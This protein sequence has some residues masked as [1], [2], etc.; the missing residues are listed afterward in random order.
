MLGLQKR[1]P[2]FKNEKLGLYNGKDFDL[3][4]K[5]NYILNLINIFWQ[6]GYSIKRLQDFIS[7]MLD[8]FERFI[9][10]NNLIIKTFGQLLNIYFLFRIYELQS[11]NYSFDST[12][13]L[14]T[15]MD[16][17]F[18]NYLNISVRDAY[19]KR[20]HISESLIND[21]VQASLRVNYGQNTNVHQFVGK[22]LLL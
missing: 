21:L 1:K 16:P 5:E 14:I 4:E 13:D 22:N 8:K 17:S 18:A 19:L 11:N 12:Y 6:Y 3:I 7:N 15:A 20:E 9:K 10:T 2:V